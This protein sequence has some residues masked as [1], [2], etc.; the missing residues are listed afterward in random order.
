MQ[1]GGWILGIMI[2]ASAIPAA[3]ADCPEGLLCASDPGGIVEA[4]T[5][6]GYDTR[7]TAADDGD[8]VIFSDASGADFAVLFKDCANNKS[9]ETLEFGYVTK[10]KT[11]DAQ[12]SMVNDQTRFVTAGVSGNDIF[13]SMDVTTIGGLNPTNF[14]SVLDNW[15]ASL[16]YARE[17][18][19]GK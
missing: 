17:V 7:L 3:A 5:A 14:G 1:P 19:D 2:G 13:V 8:P 11:P 10:S 15:A 12:A 4:M 16:T 18:L 6:A 9:C